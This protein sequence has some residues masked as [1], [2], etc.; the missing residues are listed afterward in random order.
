MPTISAPGC[1][2][3]GVAGDEDR[4]PA[5]VGVDDAGGV[6]VVERA[7]IEAPDPDEAVADLRPVARDARRKPRLR[8][9]LTD[10]GGGS[11]SGMA[12]AGQEPEG[13]AEAALAGMDGQVDRPAAADAPEVVEEPLAV[14]AEDGPVPLPARAVPRIPAVAERGGDILERQGP[15]RVGQRALLP[16][17]HGCISSTAL[18]TCSMPTWRR[19]AAA[20]AQSA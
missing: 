12:E 10:R 19:S 2:A 17:G 15:E 4:V 5:S 18:W 13:V 3:R 11:V 7:R 20:A 9:A 6:A 14:E 16:P 8:R 1:P